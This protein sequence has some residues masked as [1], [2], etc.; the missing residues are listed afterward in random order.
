[1]AI[2]SHLSFTANTVGKGNR[3]NIFKSV[4]GYDFTN[5]KSVTGYDFT[6]FP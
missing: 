2:T 3:F 5:F 1:M 4:T 6:G